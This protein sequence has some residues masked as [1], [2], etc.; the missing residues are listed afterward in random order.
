MD[1]S[2]VIVGVILIV[3]GV[4]FAWAICLGPLI[5]VAGIVVLVAGL[6]RPDPHRPVPPALRYPAYPYGPPGAR[7]FCHYCGNP[8]P[9]N[10]IQCPSC[11][12]RIETAPGP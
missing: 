2:T 10:A 8:V 11:G 9:A 7:M 4:V 6:V 1:E 5:A 12:R 3:V